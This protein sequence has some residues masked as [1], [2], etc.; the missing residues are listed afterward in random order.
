M[1]PLTY[2]SQF[3]CLKSLRFYQLF[4]QN[5]FFGSFSRLGRSESAYLLAL[6]GGGLFLFLPFALYIIK[7]FANPILVSL[8]VLK[9]P[10]KKYRD[11]CD[12]LLMFS[13]LMIF[14]VIFCLSV[15][16]YIQFSV[17]CVPF[18]VRSRLIW[19]SNL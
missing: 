6:G 16:F 5:P 14:C 9:T 7:A 17:S 8:K 10:S 18:V 3:P 13:V 19:R 11:H 1:L 12:L 15:S 2:S 4:L